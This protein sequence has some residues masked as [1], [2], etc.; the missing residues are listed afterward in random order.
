M[1]TGNLCCHVRIDME[2][3]LYVQSALLYYVLLRELG[4][5]KYRKVTDSSKHVVIG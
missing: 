4:P 2:R 3:L 1:S 5:I